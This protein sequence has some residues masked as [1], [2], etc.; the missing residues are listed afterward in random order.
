M[1]KSA[2]QQAADQK[3]GEGAATQSP[4]TAATNATGAGSSSTQAAPGAASQQ[5]SSTAT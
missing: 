4:K 1:D 2:T 5:P 3:S